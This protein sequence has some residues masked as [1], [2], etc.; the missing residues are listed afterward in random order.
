MRLTLADPGAENAGITV[1]LQSLTQM[2]LELAVLRHSIDNAPVLIWHED[3]AGDVTWANAAYLH[4]VEAQSPDDTLWP[5]PRLIDVPTAD[6]DPTTP[7]RAQM[8]WAE[9]VHWYDCHVRPDGDGRMIFAVPADAAVRAERSLREF[10]QTL[11]KTFADL[12]IGLAIFDRQRHLQLFNPALIDLTSLEAGFLTA[13]PTLYA[14]LDRLR[15]ARMVPE[16]K[17][18]RSWRNKMAT[19]EAAAASGHHVETWSLP[20]GQTYRV[21]GRPHPDGAVAFLL[22]DITSEMSL[23]RRFRAELSLGYEVLDMLDDALAVFDAS[24]RIITSNARY[25][26]QWGQNPPQTLAEHFTLWGAAAPEGAALHA[27]RDAMTTFRDR[28][29]RRGAIAGPQ[30]GLLAWTVRPL[31]GARAL[32]IFG[33]ETP[34]RAPA[35]DAP[36]VDVLTAAASFCFPGHRRHCR[37]GESRAQSR[38]LTEKPGHRRSSVRRA[39]SLSCRWNI[40]GPSAV[41]PVHARSVAGGVI[42]RT[43]DGA[44]DA[45]MG[46]ALGDGAFEIRAHP[47]GQV[48]QIIRLGDGTQQ[49]KMRDRVVTV[50]RNAHRPAQAQAVGAT[51]GDE[52]V[53]RF[54]QH[55]SLLRLVARVD[56]HEQVG[57]ASGVV[58]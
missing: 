58:A 41:R 35:A 50:G 11:T 24:G 16:P 13:R 10:V 31:S 48:V 9:I 4:E 5:M 15:E 33:A 22:E 23:T 49:A 45:D 38:R 57:L 12:P 18:Y 26:Q 25:A 44:A 46:R 34:A 36:A 28:T 32:V 54:G 29:V 43:K 52:R 2:E 17:D 53:R 39:G 42:P 56:L 55:A 3:R 20:G 19:L 7:R 37:L 6:C 40:S 14:F 47:H 21:T 27:L 1:D 8:Q 51:I 30:G